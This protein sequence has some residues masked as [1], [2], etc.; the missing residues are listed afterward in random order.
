MRDD[1]ATTP[2]P[3]PREDEA[4]G[5]FRP[6]GEILIGDLCDRVRD[7]IFRRVGQSNDG[8]AGGG[9]HEAEQAERIF[10]R[11]RALFGEC[12]CQRRQPIVQISRGLQPSLSAA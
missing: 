2:R 8:Q 4:R 7:R 3:N 12:G 1:A 5:S 11:G 9:R 10:Q 6:A